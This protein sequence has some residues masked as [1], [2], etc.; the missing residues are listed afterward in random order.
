MK[1]SAKMFERYLSSV[2]N[3]LSPSFCPVLQRGWLP[4]LLGE[5]MAPQGLVR[6]G[7]TEKF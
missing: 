7:E 4:G 3:E 1:I 6:V 2:V 5:L